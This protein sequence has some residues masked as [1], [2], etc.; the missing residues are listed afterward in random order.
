MKVV[1]GIVV[2]LLV[3]VIGFVALIRFDVAGLGTEVIGPSLVNVPVLNMI[4]PEMPEEVVDGEA[5][6]TYNFE[7]VEEAIEI[8]KITEKMLKEKGSEAEIL[9]EQ[10]VQLSAEVER[11][12]IFENNQLQFQ[13]DKEDFD[14]LIA[15]SADNM[16]YKVWF[17][18][19]E[20]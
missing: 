15:D 14:T 6:A 2:S 8:L 19:N 7:T 11:L 5:E 9:S 17:E 12:K 20:S 16:D 1:M 10:I 3:L 4:L 18:K 13:Q